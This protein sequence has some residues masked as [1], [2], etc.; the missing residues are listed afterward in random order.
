[1]DS[2][3][4]A[5]FGTFF[6][7]R[8]EI[9]LFDK[10]ENFTEE[11]ATTGNVLT[12]IHEHI[13]YFQTL[14][15]GYGHIQWSSHRQATGYTF[16][17]WKVFLP[18]M[19]AARLPLAN[20]NTRPGIQQEAWFLQ[21]LFNEQNKLNQARFLTQPSI[22]TVDDLKLHTLTGSWKINPVIEAASGPRQLYTKDILEG[23]AFF[24]ERSFAQNGL[25]FAEPVA[26]VRE[27]VGDVYTAAY[28]WFIE[29]CGSEIKS[30]FPI[31]CDLSLQTSWEPLTPTTEHEWQASN[32][33]WRFY[34]ITQALAA[35]G[36]VAGGLDGDWSA[37]YTEL[38][39]RLLDACGFK[40]INEILTE[41]LQPLMA[42]EKSVGLSPMQRIMKNA[43]VKR[44]QQPWISADPV[45]DL[46]ELSTLVTE[47]RI[48]ATVIEGRFQSQ[49]PVEN[50][51]ATELI[52][53]LHF[54]AFVSQLLGTTSR[55]AEDSNALE[56]GFTRYDFFNGCPYLAN[57]DCTGRFDP[58][59]GLP[60]PV[61]IDSTGKVEGCT[62][63]VLFKSHGFEVEDL[64]IDYQARFPI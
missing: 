13:H 11:N 1:M 37:F 6:A 48:P 24:V 59:K 4:N 61:L 55:F 12:Y 54:Q 18:A 15:T 47:F 40:P 8:L 17:N 45:R 44:L 2:Y 5:T 20:C 33:S 46:S 62:F 53:E 31:V 14:F 22:I 39:G 19:G 27:G 29:Q 28:D 42:L 49:S 21:Q 56:C 7:Q 57:G 43:M 35:E 41:R 38:C 63:G 52:G 30:L 50:E 36:N 3:L 10:A 64:E 25:G 9:R 32:P 51:V 26:W 23:H 16:G 60:V 58:K 34:L